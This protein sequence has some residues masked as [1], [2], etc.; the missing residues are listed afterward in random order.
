VAD[1]TP[2][3]TVEPAANGNA[4]TPPATPSSESNKQ[5]AQATQPTASA[6]RGVPPS[7]VPEANLPTPAAAQP[8]AQVAVIERSRERE[9]GRGRPAARSSG[10]EGRS[11]LSNAEFLK[12]DVI[13]VRSNEPALIVPVERDAG[14]PHGRQASSPVEKIA[15]VE[16]SSAKLAASSVPTA[17]PRP[18][19][20]AEPALPLQ[21][22]VQI[23]AVTVRGS[24]PTSLVR[25][26]VERI[27]PQLASC[28][29]RAAHAVGHNGF[30]ELSVEVQI[31][32]RGRARNPHANGAA[33]PQLNACVA[34]AASKLVS[35][36][37]PDTG[38]VNAS[39]KVAFTP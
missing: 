22:T 15:A 13:E 17:T 36:K 14:L 21:A 16:P 19:P 11:D 39:W 29:S 12:D 24:L 31:D 30:G 5:G 28:Y 25:R 34:D 26:A 18:P 2:I 23:Q 20:R 38:T 27:R 1:P 7:R 6:D 4:P 33:L 3:A 9:R 35:E 10:R 8:A 32:E 37:A